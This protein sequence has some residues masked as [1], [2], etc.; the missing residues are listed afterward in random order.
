MRRL[1]IYLLLDTSG[2]M[3]GEPIVAVRSG[4]S[5]LLASLRY[6]PYALE[7]VALSIITFNSE[8][9]VLIPLTALDDFQI[10]YIDAPETGATNL[11]E[12]LQMLLLKYD[13]EIIKTTPEQKGDWLPIAVIM[14]DGKPSDTLM[15]KKMCEKIKEYK[16]AHVVACAAGPKAKTEPLQQFADSVYSLDTMDTSTF[17]KFWEWVSTIVSQQ[18]QNA[19][20]TQKDELPPPPEE[21][22]LVL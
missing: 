8:V 5:S 20:S 22:K 19:D 9:E 2:S 7:T 15:F 18:S 4:L 11:G 12:A 17:N 13:T 10:P 21:I 3:R 16:F 14:T 1:P 6:N